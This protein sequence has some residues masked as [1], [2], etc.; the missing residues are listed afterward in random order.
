MFLLALKK[1]KKEMNN[2][3]LNGIRIIDLT[4]RLPGP[5]ATMQLAQMGADVFKIENTDYGQ[6]PFC[7]GELTDAAPYFKDWYSNLN[8]NKNIV[9][10]SFTNS[11]D[12]VTS[13]FLNAK[14][15]IAPDNTFFRE[16]LAQINCS[17]LFVAAGDGQFQSLHDLNA[18]ALSKSFS[19]YIKKFSQL[20]YLPIAGVAFSQNIAI[21]AME[22]LF[23]QLRDNKKKT[24]RILLKNLSEN[25]FD[26][27]YSDNILKNQEPFLHMGAFPCYQVYELSCGAKA[28]L[29]SIEAKFWINFCRVFNF[30]FSAQDRFEQHG[31]VRVKIQDLL[32]KKTFEEVEK[33]IEGHHLCLTLVR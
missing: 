14:L 11:K 8:A 21:K 31:K 3:A 7:Q 9:R 26:K 10:L 33:I 32:E 18:L 28:C 20:P 24:D 19:Q 4:S 6:D 13:H 15:I 25:L 22:M 27:L 17:I 2:N 30:N 5:M 16:Y 23:C 12:K 1:L 29:A